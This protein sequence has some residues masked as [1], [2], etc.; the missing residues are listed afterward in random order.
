MQFSAIG[1][2]GKGH[3]VYV[4][5]QICPECK[6]PIVGIKEGGPSNNVEGITLLKRFR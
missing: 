3:Y 6:E 4:Y 2:N 5:Y 1:R